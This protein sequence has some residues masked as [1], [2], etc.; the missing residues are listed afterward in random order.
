MKKRTLGKTDIKVTELGLGTWGLSGDAYGEVTEE[1][2]DEVI[3][4]ALALGITLFETAD[5]Y[6]EGRM[7]EKLG[8][9]IPKE[10]RYVIVTK[11]GTDLDS[12]PHRKRFDPEYLERRIEASAMRMSRDKLDVVL[13][14]NPSLKA[15]ERGEACELLQRLKGEDKLRAWG[16]SAGSGDVV[17]AAIERGAEVIQMPYNVLRSQELHRV[18]AA[19]AEQS[20]GVL[21]HSVL[22]YG[23]LCGQW[24]SDKQFPKGDHRR[25]RWTKEQLGERLRQAAA[26]RMTMTGPIKSQRAGALRF[27]LSNEQ[28]HAAI[29]GPRSAIQLDQLVREAGK[30]P[31]LTSDQHRFLRNRLTS[32]GA[33]T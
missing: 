7:E 32:M 10:D 30:A 23:L 9:R 18:S 12:E 19:I 1:Q 15:I 2:Q 5:V 20:V 3:D 11:V 27:V 13:L 33:K 28:V 8:A 31:Y 14:H 6:G 16:V 22:A 21:A 26:L 4:R 17:K 29:L 25:D 24:T